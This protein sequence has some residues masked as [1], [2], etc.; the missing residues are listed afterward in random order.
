MGKVGR[1][2]AFFVLMLT[3][4]GCAEMFQLGL[5]ATG[6][7]H[8]G[9]KATYPKTT[10]LD[11]FFA[12]VAGA[13]PASGLSVVSASKDVGIITMEKAQYDQ[14]MR[15]TAK[16]SEE[17]DVFVVNLSTDYK[18]DT[19]IASLQKG[20]FVVLWNIAE[21]THSDP[22]KVTVTVETKSQSLSAWITEL[23]LG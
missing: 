11:K 23:G 19:T 12:Q 20:T 10:T 3:L 15:F 17:G 5:M 1:T 2:A 18:R 9:A 8:L 21:T 14:L 13:G 4:S 6:G 16:V 22:N 7:R